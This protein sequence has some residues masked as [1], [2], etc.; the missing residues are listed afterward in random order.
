MYCCAAYS[1][2]YGAHDLML[3]LL[4]VMVLLPWSI[5]RRTPDADA[6]LDY[7][8]ILHLR[9]DAVALQDAPPGCLDATLP[10]LLPL[11]EAGVFGATAEEAEASV[12]GLEIMGFFQ[13][14]WVLGL[15]QGS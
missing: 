5:V 14:L 7:Q 12:K 8:L 9:S 4:R 2:L 3:Y 1:A 6:Y 15:S 11:V 13:G 10:R